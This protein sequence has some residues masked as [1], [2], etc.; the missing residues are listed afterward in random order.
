[1]ER[2]R[3]T[4]CHAVGLTADGFINAAMHALV[5]EMVRREPDNGEAID[6][7]RW[8]VSLVALWR[9]LARLTGEA[10]PW[11]MDVCLAWGLPIP[12]VTGDPLADLLFGFLAEL[13]AEEVPQAEFRPLQL[14]L[15]WLDLCRL[16]GEEPPRAVA[17]LLDEP[18]CAR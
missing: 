13:R 14:G 2:Q 8:E 18:A 3:A 17:A 1:M 7:L 6:P 15:V 5:D 10:V 12:R 16:A 11:Q 9:R 4:Q